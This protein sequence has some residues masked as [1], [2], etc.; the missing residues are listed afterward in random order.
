M[1]FKQEI[2]DVPRALEEM[3]EKG[4]P[5]YEAVVRATR[6]GDGP[7]YVVGSGA[8]FLAASTAASSFETLLEWPVV[9]RSAKA[10]AA[11]G[12]A[13][14]RP[15]SVLLALSHSGECEDV[16]N[17]ARAA[18]ARGATVLALTENS[19]STLAKTANAVFLISVGEK[20]KRGAKAL[21]LTAAAVS[22]IALVAARL[23]KGHQPQLD[24][25]EEEFRKLPRH[26]EWIFAQLSDAVRS[27]AAELEGCVRLCLVG[28]GFY[29]PTALEAA[30]L[31][32]LSGLEASG[33]DASEFVQGRAPRVDGQAVALLSGSRC[34]L[35]KEVHQMAEWLQSAGA[36]VLSVTDSN[37]RELIALSRVVVLLPTLTEIAG[38]LLTLVLMGCVASRIDREQG[39]N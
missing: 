34:K 22:Y 6:W 1:D 10:F 26:V 29:H 4:R 32:S 3:L 2:L 25:L 14:L 5:Q 17:V 23:L 37:D 16:L 33:F 27:F 11:Y 8:S 19:A 15:R 13:L 36:K 30:F 7:I 12:L 31:M 21:I 35:K 20:S 28:A 39:R 38:S 9:A 24:L 18:R